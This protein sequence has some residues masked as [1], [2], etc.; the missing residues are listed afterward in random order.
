MTIAGTLFNKIN[1]ALFIVLQSWFSQL[2]GQNT[3]FK[4]EKYGVSVSG[5]TSDKP[6]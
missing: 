4:V 1:L 2:T 6:K 5:N 3:K